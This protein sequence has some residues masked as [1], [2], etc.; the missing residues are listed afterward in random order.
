MT[1]FVDINNALVKPI[2]D[3]SKFGIEFNF[4]NRNTPTNVDSAF[5]QCFLLPVQP[6]QTA[7]GQDGCDQH[8]GVFQISLYFPENMGN[9]E[10]LT[11]ADEVAAVY[12][13][14]AV[15]TYN[16]VNV[17]IESIGISQG[18]NDG[19]WFIIPITINYY[20][21]IRRTP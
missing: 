7:L 15:L 3:N 17:T 8:L 2:I 12:K 18:L 13:S 21:F 14:G 10:T 5:G 19:P 20:S 16:G 9:I 1:T 4:E 11:K 6:E